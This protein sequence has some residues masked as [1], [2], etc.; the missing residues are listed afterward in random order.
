MSEEKEFVSPTEAISQVG[1]NSAESDSADV[2]T[3]LPLTDDR[4]KQ[5]SSETA[6][7]HD[8]EKAG[9]KEGKPEPPVKHSSQDKGVNIQEH[10]RSQNRR[11]INQEQWEWQQAN[12]AFFDQ[13]SIG[14]VFS[15]AGTVH[16]HQY[17]RFQSG[18]QLYDAAV[19]TGHVSFSSVEDEEIQFLASVYV[20]PP[21]L[22]DK[23]YA[24][25]EKY[26]WVILRGRPQTGKRASAF[27][28]AYHLRGG[29][30]DLHRLSAEINLKEWAS[31]K[32]LTE[33]RIYFIEGLSSVWA[34]KFHAFEWELLGKTLIEKNCYLIISARESVRFHDEDMPGERVYTWLPP[35]NVR[36]LVEKYLRY[37]GV[38]ETTMQELFDQPA[39][40]ALLNT[41]L[42]PGR[43]RILAERLNQ[44]AT[45]EVATL[46]EALRGFTVY[47]DET[48]RGLLGTALDDEER[49]FRIA[50]AVFSGLRYR[51]VEDAAAQLFALLVP[52]ET[53]T[54]KEEP[55]ALPSLFD[56]YVDEKLERAQ[57]KLIM[58]Y[59]T[60]SSLVPV[61]IVRLD[62]AAYQPALL[63]FMWR[64]FTKTRPNLLSWLYE[65]G[66]SPYREVRMRAA[67]AVAFL[68]QLEFETVVS[69][70]LFRWAVESD[71]EKSRL[72]R[73]TL[74][75][76][77][78]S[79]ASTEQFT[80]PALELLRHWSQSSNRQL[81]WAA[82]RAYG[83]VGQFY[84]REAM[85]RWLD[86]L[87]RFKF[88]ERHIERYILESL[89][90]I[91]EEPL[92]PLFDSISDAIST[93]FVLPLTLPREEFGRIYKQIITSLREWVDVENQHLFS[94]LISLPLFL[95][96]MHISITD[97]ES[98]GE[99]SSK[100]EGVKF[101]PVLLVLANSFERDD[102]CLQ[103]VAWL[104]SVAIRTP[105]TRSQTINS[106]LYGWLSYVEEDP[107][108]YPALKKVLRAVIKEDSFNHPRW[109]REIGRPFENWTRYAKNPLTVAGHLVEKLGLQRQR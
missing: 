75:Y 32:D 91:V 48:I 99:E 29:V 44:Y 28:M 9:L 31:G 64:K 72:C 108:L 87:I 46:E 65:Q 100:P 50:L 47:D 73:A 60:N 26:H 59:P 96:L 43:A 39:V 55:V 27:F 4:G 102:P 97:E 78:A 10:I 49:A 81:V 76:T 42:P 66:S 11:A 79:L 3:D 23:A 103:D 14:N 22:Y 92:R 53:R 51:T 69:Q 38:S 56:T 35:D 94:I 106:G 20:K 17:S 13:S 33:N 40:V 109:H 61:E 105:E 45:G 18:Q 82:A 1:G 74:S 88:V 83:V 24:C 5:T 7:V 77:F 93:F 37:Y 70:V 16:I 19:Q 57:A 84:P 62:D 2:K 107:K 25:L 52:T 34:Q 101:A 95:G 90:I 41:H 80:D 15:S 71:R 54:K 30:P 68:A 6:E 89:R 36:M 85:E 86:I 21:G 98:V 104:L 63:S 8:D 67:A 12:S 58:D